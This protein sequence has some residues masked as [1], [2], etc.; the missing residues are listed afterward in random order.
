MQK[1]ELKEN[2]DREENLDELSFSE[3]IAE[4]VKTNT[5]P[6]PL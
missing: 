1:K 4:A 3:I 5:K 6:D 2:K